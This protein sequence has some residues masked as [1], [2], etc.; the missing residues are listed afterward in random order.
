[1]PIDCF[2]ILLLL[3]TDQK[4]HPCVSV[5]V[6]LPHT[7]NRTAATDCVLLLAGFIAKSDFDTEH[8]A[9]YFRGL[10][11]WDELLSTFDAVFLTWA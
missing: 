11:Q 1:M 4:Y 8:A 5:V 2:R 3:K 7:H 6:V 9:V 10:K